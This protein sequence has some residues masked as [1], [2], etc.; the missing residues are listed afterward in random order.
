MTARSRSEIIAAVA[1]QGFDTLFVNSPDSIF[2]LDTDGAFV[3]VNSVLQS[4]LRQPLDDIIGQDYRF[5]VTGEA[6]EQMTQAFATA[7]EGDRT[8]A[9]I[10]GVTTTGG[11]IRVEVVYAPVWHDGEVIAVI[12][13]ARDT[14]PLEIEAQSRRELEAKLSTALDA[15]SDGLF[16]LDHDWNFTYSNPQAERIVKKPASEMMGKSLWDVFPDVIGSEFGIAY[17]T[18][19]EERRTV[20]VRDVYPPLGIFLE[21]TAYPNDSGLAVYF[22][23]VTAEEGARARARSAEER[24]ASQAKLL[25]IARDAIIVRGVDHTIHYWNRAA[26]DLYGWSS[27]EALGNS[28]REL[29]YDDPAEFDVATALTVAVGHW[30]GELEQRTKSGTTIVSDCSWTLVPGAD[31]QPDTIFAVNTDITEKKEQEEL[32]LRT[33]R[34]ESLGTLAGGIAHDLNNILTPMLMSVQLLASDEEDTSKLE[35]LGVIESSV[36]RGADMIRQ[37]LSFARGVEGRRIRVDVTRLVRDV[38]AFSREAMPGMIAVV[39]HID[40]DLDDVIGDP[41]QLQQVLV[42]F[43]TN[44]RDAMPEGGTL[45]IRA[46]HAEA[47]T[48]DGLGQ[49]VLLEVSD[50]GT[51]IAPDVQGKIFEPFFTTKLV[52]E[53]TGLGLATSAAIV[54]S[55]GGRLEVDSQVGNGS[56]FKLLLPKSLANESVRRGT[57]V[58]RPSTEDYPR[59]SGQLILIVDDEAS[60]RQITRHALEVSG[61]QTAVASNGDEGFEVVNSRGGDVALVLTDMMMPDSDGPQLIGRLA[62][63]FP[64]IPI[65]ASSGLTGQ[66]ESVQGKIAGFLGKPYTSMQLLQ[67]V[68][69][70]LKAKG[71]QNNG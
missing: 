4:Q 62:E 44:A 26:S 38:V 28:I 35:I 61:Y 55:H 29:I 41:T 32:Q 2:V 53:G 13:I 37:V 40:D 9:L 66:L 6:K 42:N 47:P 8:Q 25:D 33:Q 46:T 58:G 63:S 14:A 11:L 67:A 39:D 21:V 71:R 60:I 56:T 10:T 24:I 50:T 23:D 43:I 19:V 57:T 12:G 69:D 30:S 20:V 36:K 31:N 3:L 70:A 64:D 16:F 52:G 51:G 68:N 1:N 48:D 34:M 18:A 49:F 17:R 22:R 15:I 5:R 54:K 59:G 27:A 65:I 7:V 45:S